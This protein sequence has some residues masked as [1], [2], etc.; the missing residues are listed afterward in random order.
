VLKA[1][2]LIYD[3]D[4]CKNHVICD[5]VWVCFYILLQSETQFL[6]VSLSSFHPGAAALT[7]EGTERGATDSC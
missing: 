5:L 7:G 1:D 6:S 2:D 3:F 4:C